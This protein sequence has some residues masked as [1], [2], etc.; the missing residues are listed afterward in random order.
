MAY[1]LTTGWGDR[2]KRPLTPSNQEASMQTKRL[3]QVAG[4]LGVLA[5]TA[6]CTFG[7][8]QPTDDNGLPLVG[9]T[10]TPTDSI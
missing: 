3:L 6:A 10:A 8:L 4:V 5:L 1:R 7:P 9:D 2:E